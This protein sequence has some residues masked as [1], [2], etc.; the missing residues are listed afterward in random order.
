VRVGVRACEELGGD[1]GVRSLALEELDDAAGA[2]RVVEG[3]RS[4]EARAED[5]DVLPAPS[6]CARDGV[7]VEEAAEEHLAAARGRGEDRLRP[8]RRR[9]DQR[10]RARLEELARR[11]PDV[12][13]LDPDGA[14]LAADER[15]RQLPAEPPRVLEVA[16]AEDTPVAARERLRDRRGGAENVDDDPDG[17]GGFFGG[18]EGDVDANDGSTLVAWPLRASRPATATPAASRASRAPSAD[19]RSARSA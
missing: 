9:E 15:V 8:V 11:R 16:T 4:L 1:R 12:E 18:G 19:A 10:L 17:S 14:P 13:A 5:G 3:E 2:V 7:E 6:R